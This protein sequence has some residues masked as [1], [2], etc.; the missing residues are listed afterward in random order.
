M[1]RMEGFQ[2]FRQLVKTDCLR[3]MLE[4]A[5]ML[6]QNGLDVFFRVPVASH[7]IHPS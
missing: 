2:G 4:R 1:N 7:D 6:L 5:V 3:R